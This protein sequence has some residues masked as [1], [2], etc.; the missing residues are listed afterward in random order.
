MSGDARTRI[1]KNIEI[2]A[3]HDVEIRLLQDAINSRG[4]HLSY[5]Q[6]IEKMIDEFLEKLG[7]TSD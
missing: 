5:S 7:K 1:R 2:R 4:T 6:I 3:D